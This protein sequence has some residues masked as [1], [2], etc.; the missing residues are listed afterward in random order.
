[1]TLTRLIY[2]DINEKGETIEQDRPSGAHAEHLQAAKTINAEAQQ[3]KRADKRRLELTR[4]ANE[5]QVKHNVVSKIL[6]NNAEV[7]A[8]LMAQLDSN[9]LED[10]TI[11][12]FRR[13]TVS[14]LQDFIHV[15]KFT[16]HQFLKGKLTPAGKTLK[17]TLYAGQTAES[18]GAD[19]NEENPCLVWLAYSL[20][21]T[22]VVLQ[23]NTVPD[24]DTGW[25]IPNF[26]VA[27]ATRINDKCPSEY[28]KNKDW[29]E[30]FKATVKGVS[31]IDV[32]EEV[33]D[34]AKWLVLAMQQ[35]IDLHVDERVDRRRHHHYSLDYLRDNIPSLAAGKCLTDQIVENV[36]SFRMDECLFKIPNED[37]SNGPF[38]L[39]S[40][41][42]AET[43]LGK[44]EGS[45]LMFDRLKKKW[46][47]S[48]MTAGE[49][50]ATCFSGRIKKHTQNARSVKEMI[51]Y[52]FY[53]EHP[54]KGVENIRGNMG[55]HW[56]DLIV[57]CG[58]AFDQHGDNGPL[59]N[60]LYEW[61]KQ[62][63]DNLERMDGSLENN[64]Q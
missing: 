37:A 28:L 38:K 3:I 17:K 58:M 25:S 52:P 48:G 54:A 39:I 31:F 56:D 34:R 50:M 46:V 49:G 8:K 2:S 57:F 15:R 44:L 45:Y 33:V 13:L 35:R 20:R 1:M 60:S 41:G 9:V 32:D 16:G 55:K 62:T 7:E 22:D 24:A 61:S 5:A 59:F 19:C 51:Q 47:R 18:I 10:A 36:R 63:T 26:A 12:L 30:S 14:E 64:K 53:Q 29:V 23:T 6:Q 27:Y 40:N 43:V 42:M 4:K 21:T 11:A